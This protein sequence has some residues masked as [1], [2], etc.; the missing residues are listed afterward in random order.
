MTAT[1]KDKATAGVGLTILL[2]FLAA[3][4]EGIDLQSAG[5]AAGGI[6]GAFHLDD[7]QM[8]FVLAASPFGLL[9]GAIAGGRLADMVGRKTVLVGSVAIFGVFSLITA[10]APSYETLVAIRVLTGLGLGG[11]TP[12]L[13]ALTGEAAKRATSAAPVALVFAGMPVGGALVS[14]VGFLLGPMG[15]WRTIFYIG[16]IVPILFAPLIWKYLPESRRFQ[17]HKAAM[18]ADAG[19]VRPSVV[20]ALFAENRALTSL[21]LWI[22]SFFTLLILYLLLNWLP[23]LM[24][25]KGFNREQGMIIQMFFN[26]GSVLGGVVLGRLMDRGRR[27]LILFVTYIGM[28]SSLFALGAAPAGAMVTSIIAAIAVGFFVVG[29]QFVL[30][31]LYPG[32]YSTRIRGTGA[33]AAT[34]VGRVGAIAGPL[35]A[36]VL[37]SGGKTSTEVLQ[38]L[39]PVVLV[40]GIAAVALIWRPT[41][42]E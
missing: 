40:G 12:N 29:G 42:D 11:A 39:L 35:L 4:I 2:C 14:Y 10:F 23:L 34:A 24:G 32:F 17:E 19:D 20:S 22:A 31:G 41:V 30:Y 38:S 3:V 25:G 33:G 15:D 6:K 1:D 16:G 21:L 13:I 7:G 5:V 28:A 37:L 9:L 26:G 18:A 36:G 8:K 27:A